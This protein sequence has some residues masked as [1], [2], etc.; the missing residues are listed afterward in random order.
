[1]TRRLQNISG[2]RDQRK[3]GGAAD[4][5]LPKHDCRTNEGVCREKPVSKP[6]IVPGCPVVGHCRRLLQPRLA[7][8][9]VMLGLILDSL[10]G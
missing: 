6:L 8:F 1:L 9:F 2:L 3:P 4:D 7:Q 10:I 5:D